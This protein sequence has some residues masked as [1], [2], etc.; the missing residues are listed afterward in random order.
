[1]RKG[2][3]LR[4]R[5]ESECFHFGMPAM[6]LL[7]HYRE[8][9]IRMG[10]SDNFSTDISQLLHISNVKYSYRASNQVN[11]MCQV[12]AHNDRQTAFDYI[13]QTLRWLALQ[14]WHDK[15]SAVILNLICAAEKQRFPRRARKIEFLLGNLSSFSDPRFRIRRPINIPGSVPHRR[16]T[17]QY[18]FPKLPPS[19]IFQH[20]PH[21]FGI[22]Y[23][24]YGVT[25]LYVFFG[26][27]AKTSNM[28][29]KSCPITKCGFSLLNFTLRL[30]SLPVFRL[31]RAD[32]SGLHLQEATPGG[33]GVPRG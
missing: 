32:C 13:H 22:S 33:L 18:P 31:Q 5:L 30:I 3:A 11:F 4:K 7:S 14:G 23:I 26:V 20:F 2:P 1:M 16:P 8:C 28:R 10:A 21:K 15:D 19:S 25:T 24:A 9:I 17:N 27:S 12:L 6:H 29:F